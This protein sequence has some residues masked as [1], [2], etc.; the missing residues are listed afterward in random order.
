MAMYWDKNFCF[1]IISSHFQCFFRVAVVGF[2]RVVIAATDG[3]KSECFILPAM[4]LPGLTVVVSPLKALMTDQYEQRIKER[5]GLHQ[6]TTWFNGDVDVSERMKRLRAM[7]RGFYK[8]AYFT[9]EQLERSHVLDS[10]ARANKNVG[11]RYL[12]MDEAH[13]I[14]Q[15]GHD[16]R[17]AYLN[18]LRRLKSRSEER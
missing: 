9:P 3:G 4:L 18:V 12:A 1:E 7:E 13:C 17:P 15:W 14:S 2:P 16:F 6:V 10:L 11:V 8:L 5:Y